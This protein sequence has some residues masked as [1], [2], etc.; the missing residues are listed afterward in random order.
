[1]HAAMDFARLGADVFHDVDFAACGPADYVDVVSK[2]PKRGPDALT[3]G[4]LEAR[5]K[6]PIGLSEAGGGLNT[7]RCVVAAYRI[8]TGEV[9]F[10]HGD[11]EISVLL[12]GVLRPVGVVLT[13]IVAPAIAAGFEHPLGGI[14]RGTVRAVELVSPGQ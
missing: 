4:H 11:D 7:S 9:L 5:L 10:Q 14:Q 3:L 1:M 2:H 12:R 8:G 6:P 13:L